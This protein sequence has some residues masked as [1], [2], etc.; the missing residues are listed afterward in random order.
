M[1]PAEA[2]LRG[3]DRPPAI[4]GRA[5][6]SKGCMSTVL[7]LRPISLAVLVFGADHVLVGIDYLY[8]IAESDPLGH[9]ASVSRFDTATVAAIAAGKLNACWGI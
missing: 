4:K 9:L 5:T 6:I 7:S 2:S 1:T 8:D 3:V